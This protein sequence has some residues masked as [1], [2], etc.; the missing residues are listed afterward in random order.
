MLLRNKLRRRGRI[1]ERLNRE[2]AAGMGSNLRLPNARV[3]RNAWNRIVALDVER[4]VL[5]D[6]K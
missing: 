5:V 3:N 6:S 4:I 2:S 1:E